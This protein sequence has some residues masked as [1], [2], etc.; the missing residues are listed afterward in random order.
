[1]VFN[2]I[3]ATATNAL[4]RVYPKGKRLGSTKCLS[5]DATHPCFEIPVNQ[6]AN[7]G[8]WVQLTL[9]NDPV[10]AWAFTKYIGY[11][12]VKTKNLSATETLG[13][14]DVRFETSYTK[15][16]NDGSVLADAAELGT[17]PSDWAC[18]K[19]NV[20][21]LRWEVKTDDGGLRD[22]DHTYSWYD[23]AILP[24]NGHQPGFQNLGS[25]TGGISC[26]TEGYVNAVNAQA[27]C[28]YSDWRMP[29]RAEL[30]TIFNKSILPRIDHF[31]FPNTPSSY[32]WSST[33]YNA[34]PDGSM[35]VNFGAGSDLPHLSSRDAAYAVRLVRGGQ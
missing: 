24:I 1:L 32:F 14:E 7:K 16:A 12:V 33:T 17:A 25:C 29:S 30:Y 18:T 19:D 5:S 8:K 9:N 10:T 34:S 15:I 6:S 28:G 22:K 21:G 23:S 35:F 20:T 26:D 13:V 27:L 11:V 4:F 3:H 2:T 31:Y